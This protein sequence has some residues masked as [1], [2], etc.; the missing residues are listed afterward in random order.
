MPMKIA[1]NMGLSYGWVRG[2]DFWGGPMNETLTTLDT[3]TFLRLQSITF[4][5]PPADA[6]NGDTYFI[7]KN[8]TGP[9]VGQERKLA[10][11]IEGVWQFIEP[12]RGWRAFLDPTSEFIWWDGETWRIENTGVDPINPNPSPDVVPMAFDVS[13]TISEKMYP[14]EVLVHLPIIDNMYLP[15][16]MAQSQFDARSAFLDKAKFTVQRNNQTVGTFTVDRGQYN[17]TFVTSGSVA[18]RFFKGD[19]LTILAPVDTIDSAVNF[20]F[21]IRLMIQGA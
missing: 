13:A 4:S 10:V 14:S 6:K 20:G 1:P 11:L 3:V 21:I 19:R 18:V 12:K 15:A 5:A 9:W 8:P 2:E 16:N 17:A 7:Y